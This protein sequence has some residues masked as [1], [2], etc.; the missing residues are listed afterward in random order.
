MNDQFTLRSP[1]ALQRDESVL[2]VVDVQ[3][4]LVDLTPQPAR[5]RW[6]IRRLI[7]CAQL[8]E[9]PITVT[10]QNPE[11]LG[12]T[13]P[14]LV[15]R[16]PTAHSKMAFSCF[17]CRPFVEELNGFERRQIVVVGIEAHVCVLQTSL[18]LLAAGYVIHMPVDA[19]ASR[20]TRDTEIALRRLESN[21]AVL[22]TTETAMFEWCQLAGSDR[23]RAVS[24]LVRESPPDESQP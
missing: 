3:D 10:E 18:D 20:H 13:S 6:N 21:G 11:K 14:E 2:L 12:P 22:T 17:G 5:L 7:D 9:I 4:R 24:K 8:F 19:I 23:F 16:L 1:E 15:D